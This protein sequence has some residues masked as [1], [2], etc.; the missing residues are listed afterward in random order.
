MEPSKPLEEQSQKK[1]A[2]EKI[3]TGPYPVDYKLPVCALDGAQMRSDEKRRPLSNPLEQPEQ[4]KQEMKRIGWYRGIEEF[5]PLKCHA[6][7]NAC[8]QRL[9][10]WDN[11]VKRGMIVEKGSQLHTADCQNTRTFF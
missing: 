7:H 11:L 9:R 2:R 3:Q 6:L 5:V 8:Y 1:R 4:F 10:D